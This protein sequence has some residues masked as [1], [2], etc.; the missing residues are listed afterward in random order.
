MEGE[1]GFYFPTLLRDNVGFDDQTSRLLTAVS[2]TV[3]LV[4]AFGSLFVIDRW[5]RRKYVS[6]TVFFPFPLR[7][8]P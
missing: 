6:F 7:F 3:Y 2:G 4:A 5:G 8:A 1:T